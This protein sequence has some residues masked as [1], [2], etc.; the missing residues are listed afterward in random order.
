MNKHL[1]FSGFAKHKLLEF[2]CG[3][4]KQVLLV[5]NYIKEVKYLT[6]K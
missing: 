1:S 4:L 5:E 6:E 3:H 2:G